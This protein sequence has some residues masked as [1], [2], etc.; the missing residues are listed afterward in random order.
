MTRIIAIANQKGGVG[1]TTTAVNLAA[2]LAHLKKK[3]LLIDMDPQAN[4]T[5]SMGIDNTF[6]EYCM[7]DVLRG[8]APTKK[9]IKLTKMDGVSVLPSSI[10]LAALEFE[11][12]D[13]PNRAHLLQNALAKD[14]SKYDYIIIDSPP[15]LGLL[16]LNALVVADSVL[17]PMQ[18]EY[19]SMEGIALLLNTVR[20][21]QSNYNSKLEI[22]GILLTMTDFRTKYAMEVQKEVRAVFKEK[23]YQ[24]TIPRNVRLVE[25]SSMGM[26]VIMFDA[27]SKGA[28]AYLQVAKEVIHNESKW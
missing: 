17:I 4:S 12:K 1:K 27:S 13:Q 11:M 20:K 6:V 21:V 15:S 7:K 8:V 5:R 22:E 19:F 18:C 28:K 9:V 2:S 3:V 26:P 24:T 23:T 16:S 25:A 14:A 10:D